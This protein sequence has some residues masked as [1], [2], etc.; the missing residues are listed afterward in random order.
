MAKTIK[1][2]LICDGNPVRTIEDLQNN[3][4]VEDI[5]GYYHNKLLH[6]WLEVRGYEDEL[7]KVSEIVAIDDMEVIKRLVE[8][9]DV[10]A[11]KNMLKYFKERQAYYSVYEKQAYEVEN[12]LGDH[13]A[14]YIRMGKCGS[15]KYG[16]IRTAYHISY[17]GF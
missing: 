10:A 4:S 6:R 13:L 2:N 15:R 16:R 11:D 17:T 8:I 1:F 5:L 14:G 3:F 7:R 12:I 9:F